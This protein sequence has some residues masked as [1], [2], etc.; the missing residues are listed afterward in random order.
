M[1]KLMM[2]LAWA[3]AC[4]AFA[5]GAHAQTVAGTGSLH[6]LAIGVCPPYR[7][8]IPVEVCRNSTSSITQAFE[9][10]V[11]VS[12]DNITTLIDENSTGRNFLKTLDDYKNTLTS[13]DRLLVYLLMHGDAFSDWANYYNATG[14]VSAVSAPLREENDDVLVFWTKD[15]PTVPALALAEKDWLSAS[16]I[17]TALESVKAKVSVILE[18]CSSGLFFAGLSKHALPKPNVD[19]VVTSSGPN[20]VSNFDPSLK[21][22]LFTREFTTATQV[23][24]V[25]TFGQAIEQARVTTTIHASAQCASA[26]IGARSYSGRYPDLPRPPAASGDDPVVVPLWSCAQVPNHIDLSGETSSLKLQ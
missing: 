6:V 15:E 5:L 12:K 3:V 17:A 11:G 14:W 16:E 23:P 22:S 25:T 7:T 1:F 10:H 18:S 24:T 4:S 2:A 21:V 9:T 19:F 20:Q 26:S 8:H 13:D